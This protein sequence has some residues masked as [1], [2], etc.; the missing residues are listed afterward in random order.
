M[1]LGNLSP[2]R[3]A[4]QTDIRNLIDRVVIGRETIRI[5]LS[6]V[7]EEKGQREDFDA[8]LDASVTLSQARDPPGRKPQDPCPPDARQRAR[9][10]DRCP[11]RRAPL[12]GLTSL[13]SPPDFGVDRLARGQNCAFDPDDFVA[14]FPRARDRQSG[15]RRTPAAR[16]WSQASRRP[17]D[18]LAGSVARARTPGAGASVR[19]DPR[20]R[21]CL[22]A[23]G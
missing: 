10:F 18:G 16:L 9:D 1:P 7:A 4:S 11:S 15:S 19:N 8:S 12:A 14:R 22:L 17:A 6:E 20:L 5:E 3:A 23:T 2:D 13:R 21:V